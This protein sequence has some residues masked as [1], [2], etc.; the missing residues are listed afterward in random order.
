M[1]DLCHTRHNLNK[2]EKR[3]IETKIWSNIKLKKSKHKNNLIT[4]NISILKTVK[5]R[6]A[7]KNSSKKS[8]KKLIQNEKDNKSLASLRKLKTVLV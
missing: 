4:E 8:Q 1:I 3:K 7:K 6:N 5:N 2:I